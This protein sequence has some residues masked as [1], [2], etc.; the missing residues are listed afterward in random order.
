MKIAFIVIALAAYAGADE[1]YAGDEAS[2]GPAVDR[3][4]D[5]VGLAGGDE[6]VMGITICMDQPASG[7]NL[8]GNEATQPQ[9]VC[10][11]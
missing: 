5:V 7:L 9:M 3:A 6:M 2:G 10:R 1:G 4:G 11:R 8:E